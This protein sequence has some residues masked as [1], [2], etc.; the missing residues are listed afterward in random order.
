MPEQE[1]KG[2]TCFPD[3]SIPFASVVLDFRGSTQK[4][5]A[6]YFGLSS[7][8]MDMDLTIIKQPHVKGEGT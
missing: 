4:G 1:T 5:T 3:I 8:P 6:Q 7:F 2:K